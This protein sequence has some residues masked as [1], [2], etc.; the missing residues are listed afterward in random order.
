M[1]AP[2]ITKD[3]FSLS[4]MAEAMYRAAETAATQAASWAR[5]SSDH[6]LM[7]ILRDRYRG[8]TLYCYDESQENRFAQP[9]REW[10]AVATSFDECLAKMRERIVRY[11]GEDA[12]VTIERQ[13]EEYKDE[14]QAPSLEQSL[15]FQANRHWY[16]F[17]CI[18]AD[19]FC[20]K[21]ATLIA[22]TRKEKAE[23]AN[24]RCP[25]TFLDD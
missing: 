16:C 20:D 9:P 11:R 17:F 6:Q 4:S 22:L 25:C 19:D 23:S 7:E 12:W 3:V 1:S 24:R 18:T 13:L 8:Q 10:N 21:V 15:V 5:T 14:G 2:T